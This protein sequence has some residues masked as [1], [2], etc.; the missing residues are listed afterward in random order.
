[1]GKKRRHKSAAPLP[2][3]RQ[4]VEGKLEVPRALALWL[5]QP[6]AELLLRWLETDE[7]LGGDLP[8][9]FRPLLSLLPTLRHMVFCFSDS[10]ER[11][12][13]ATVRAKANSFWDQLTHDLAFRPTMR[14]M[15]K[16]RNVNRKRLVEEIACLPVEE[17]IEM[18][19][20]SIA[21]A[22]G[23]G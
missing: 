4:S 20:E 7:E 11:L 15:R 16:D 2:K 6:M 5:T 8:K 21:H 19:A 9:E 10:A 22:K 12:K 14:R 23:G 17:V 1:M 13:E 18:V 3:P